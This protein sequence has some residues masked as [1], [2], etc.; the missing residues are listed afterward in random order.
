MLS[1][2]SHSFYTLS[3]TTT[4]VAQ[5]HTR[6]HRISTYCFDRYSLARSTDGRIIIE[7]IIKGGVFGFTDALRICSLGQYR[8]RFEHHGKRNS[9]N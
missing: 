8:Q 4:S 7:Y 9:P 3:S 1:L 6:L 5:A 2:N